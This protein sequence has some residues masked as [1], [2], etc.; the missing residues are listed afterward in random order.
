MI[1]NYNLTV[2]TID[3]T[4][5]T[6]IIINTND[7]NSIK[8]SIA[9]TQNNKPI[10][11]SEANVRI[12]I[13]KPDKKTVLQDCAIVDAINGECEVLLNTQAYSTSGFYVAEIMV[14]S[15]YLDLERVTVTGRFSYSVAQGILDE[16]TTESTNDWQAIHQVIADAEAILLDLKENDTGASVD[17]EARAD[18]EM[19][20]SDLIQLDEKVED[21]IIHKS[22]TVPNLPLGGLWLDT[23]DD[24]FQGTVFDS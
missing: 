1:K 21:A 4:E 24:P 16:T 6:S 8:F 20:K 3:K 23:S 7:L 13:V 15:V 5:P 19:V 17:T 11:L 10:D 12:S 14:Y 9:I 18:I 2:D 22:D